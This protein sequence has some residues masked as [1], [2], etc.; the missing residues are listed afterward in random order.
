M[1][2]AVFTSHPV[3]YQAPFFRA[4]ARIVNLKV[5]FAHEADELN[6]AEAGFDVGFRWDSNILAGYNYEF[7]ENVAKAPS[8]VRFNGCDTPS[9]FQHMRH[10][11]YDAVIVYGWHMKAYIQTAVACR[12]Y[13]IPVYARTDSHARS[14][15]NVY[16]RLLKRILYPV[17]SSLF[18]GYLPV[19]KRSYEYLLKYGVTE[20]YIRRVPYCVDDELYYRDESAGCAD[21]KR[22]RYLHGI[23]ETDHVILYSGKFIECKRLDVLLRAFDSFSNGNKSQVLMLVGSG[24]EEDRLKHMA[25]GMSSRIIFCGFENQSRLPAY[26]R[27]ADMTV[28]PS[29]SESWGM[30]INESLACGTPVIVSDAVGCS[31]D[32]VIDGK[33]GMIFPVNDVKELAECMQTMIVACNNYKTGTAIAEMAGKYTPDACAISM[34][35]AVKG[36]NSCR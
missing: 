5:I 34:L 21:R 2:L 33:T 36:M 13:G 18:S 27:A 16:R 7:V 29:E 15:S 8:L 35:D 30:V 1:R 6:Q 12:R 31:D 9:I 25:E 17:I 10:A 20:K 23:D 28:L 22:M 11:G 26:Y 32:L 19:G 14:N 4:L 24:P 3:Q